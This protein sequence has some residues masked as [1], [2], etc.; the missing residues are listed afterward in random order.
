MCDFWSSVVLS[1]GKYKG[2][3]MVKHIHLPELE[4]EHFTHWLALFKENANE[5]FPKEIAEV[6]IEKAHKIAE[7]L[8]YGIATHRGKLD[9]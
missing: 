6:F 8:I 7:S 4:R 3:P 1:T 5:L 2:Q 9:L